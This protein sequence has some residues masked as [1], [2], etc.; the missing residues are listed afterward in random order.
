MAKYDGIEDMGLVF[1]EE[2]FADINDD[3]LKNNEILYRKIAKK[4]TEAYNFGITEALSECQEAIS[5]IES[6]RIK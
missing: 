5:A 1:A 2:L 3:N 6:L 4:L